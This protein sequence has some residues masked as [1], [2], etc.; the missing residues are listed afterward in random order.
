MAQ[1]VMINIPGIGMVEATNAATE[2]TLRELLKAMQKAGASAAKNTGGAGGAGGSG[3]GGAGGGMAGMTK[4]M[5]GATKGLG[6]LA[7]GLGGVANIAGQVAMKFLEVGAA[8]ANLIR[9]MSNVGDSLSG[10]AQSLDAIPIVGGTLATVFGAVAEA[11][12]KSARSFQSA[13]S[14]GASFGGNMNSFIRTAS[15][16]GM[17]MDQFG[18]LVKS[19]GIGMMGFGTTVEEGAKRFGAVSKALRSSSNDLYALGFSTQDINEGLANYGKLMRLTG[20]S[21]NMTTQELANGAKSYLKEMDA[22]AKITGEDRKQQEAKMERLAKDGQYQMM[23][24]Q[25]DEKVR[26]SFDS[27]MGQVPAELQGFIKD[28]VTTGTVTSEENGKIASLMGADVMNEL[29]KY[30]AKLDKGEALTLAER[31]KMNNLLAEGSRRVAQQYGKTLAANRDMDGASNAITAGLKLQKDA[32]IKTEAEQNKATKGQDGLNKK[33]EESKARLAAM[34]NGFTQALLN[35]GMIDSLMD[36]FGMLANFISTFVVPIFRIFG[37]ILT[38]IVSILKSVLTPVFETLA[39]V[40]STV[41]IPFQWMS[42]KLDSVNVGFDVLGFAMSAILFPI[43]L[44]ADTIGFLMKG[45]VSLIDLSEDVLYPVFAFLGRMFDN[46]GKLLKDTFMPVIDATTKWFSSSFK[47]IMD[48][49]APVINP[50]VG[51]FKAVKTAI[52]NFFNSF[53]TIGEVITSVGFTFKAFQLQLKEMWYA[54]KDLIPGLTDTTTEEREALAKERE[55]LAEDRV[56]HDKQL[57]QNKKENLAKEEAAQRARDRARAERDKKFFDGRDARQGAL[58]AA[59]DKT[60]QAAIDNA[61]GGKNYLDPIQSLKDFKGG[62]AQPGAQTQTPGGSTVPGSAPPAMKQDTKQNMELIKASLAKQGITDPK[63]IAATLGNV[64]K[65]TGGKNISE[66]MNYGGTSNDRIRKIFGSRAAG[67]TEAE[68]NS[69]KADPKQMGEMMYGSGT[70]MG[71]QMGNLEPGDGWKYRGRG[72]IQLTGKSNYAAASKAIF[73]DDRL[74]KNPDLLDNPQVAADVSAWY[75]KKGQAGMAKKLGIDTSNMSQADANLLATSQIAGGDIRKKGAI[76]RELS[77]KVDRYASQM[78]S[79]AGTPASVM[80]S[81]QS[82]M[83]T[84][85]ATT[86]VGTPGT[87]T[88][89]VGTPGNKAR[90][91]AGGT[92]RPMAP[93]QESAESLLSSL[94]NKMDQLISINRNLSDVNEKQLRVQKS[95]SSDG[96]TAA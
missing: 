27:L 31:N 44:L 68:L 2:D 59:A 86:P 83:S 5:A 81:N 20:R 38:P 11:A 23:I 41:M 71:Q 64:M 77:E 96:Y 4:G 82:V 29:Q 33:I 47:K 16:A 21:Q 14:A 22:L 55:K 15:Q 80:P 63:M 19:N 9:S 42:Y 34:S 89:P 85:A 13:A 76:G 24:S 28:V 72:F 45:F 52:S 93:A 70:K 25:K 87:A 95:L 65:E 88:A 53:N 1:P 17:T 48:T 66:N 43:N 91:Q 54:I 73:G 37:A 90:D 75:M 50:V 8:S 30:H 32:I 69:I 62:V 67:K 18:A 7:K 74:V 79:I 39:N 46:V 36:T 49:L 26:K 94:N 58:D 40:L 61:P 51:A 84:P 56:G 6:A 3:A 12:E 57:E 60:A 92:T 10:A 78:S 35:S